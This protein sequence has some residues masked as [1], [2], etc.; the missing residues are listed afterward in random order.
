MGRR[1]IW[2]LLFVLAA[3][4]VGLTL[5]IKPWKAFLDQRSK[6]DA[7][8]REMQLAEKSRED[9]TRKKAELESKPGRELAARE[10]GYTKPGE[11]PAS[12]LQ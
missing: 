6:A 9:L 12:E 5:S 11:K 2:N 1:L 3:V 4:A 8:R 7:S 10:L